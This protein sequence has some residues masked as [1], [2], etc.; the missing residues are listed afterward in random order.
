LK[1]P[2]CECLSGSACGAKISGKCSVDNDS[3]CADKMWSWWN[4][5]FYSA[6]PCS[7]S[8]SAAEYMA[9]SESLT[10][11]DYLIYGFALVGAAFGVFQCVKLC[12]KTPRS[13]AVRHEEL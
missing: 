9:I 11:D 7:S 13:T 8:G 3:T 4:F 5:G 1:A 6:E 12:T 2:T 10:S